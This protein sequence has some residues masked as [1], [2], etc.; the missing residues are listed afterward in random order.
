M[1]VTYYFEIDNSCTKLFSKIIVVVAQMV[2]HNLA[3]VAV[4]SSNL[5]DY[6]YSPDS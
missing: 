5:V 1:E 6:Y 3:K 4:A 2:E